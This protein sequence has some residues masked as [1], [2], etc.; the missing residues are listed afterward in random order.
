MG[1]MV[2]EYF[3]GWAGQ[4]VHSTEANVQACVTKM[5]GL[6]RGDGS[7]SPGGYRPGFGSTIPYRLYL[8]Q[9]LYACTTSRIFTVPKVKAQVL[10]CE[11]GLLEPRRSNT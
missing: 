11:F 7:A 1:E 5:I 4:I 2:G 3:C 9:D 6:E 10:I 8:V